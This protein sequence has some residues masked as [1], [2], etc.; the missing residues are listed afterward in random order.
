MRRGFR[1]PSG[2]RAYVEHLHVGG[3]IV[4]SREAVER[5]LAQVNGISLDGSGPS[6]PGSLSS[7]RRKEELAQAAREVEALAL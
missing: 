5:Y 3:K 7:K 6:S 4:S 1:T 2:G